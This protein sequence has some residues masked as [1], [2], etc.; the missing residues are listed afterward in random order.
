M[1]NLECCLVL[2]TL[3]DCKLTE[4]KYLEANQN[5]ALILIRYTADLGSSSRSQEVSPAMYQTVV[6]KSGSLQL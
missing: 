2:R 3:K 5:H 1:V 4:L 6:I